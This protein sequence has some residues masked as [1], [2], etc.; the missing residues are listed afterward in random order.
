MPTT[1]DP[2]LYA[3]ALAEIRALRPR[4]DAEQQA[5]DDSE[6]TCCTGDR[7]GYQWHQRTRNLPACEQSSAANRAYINA[8]RAARRRKRVAA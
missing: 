7:S 8:F 2:E 3:Q 6:P 5:I 4:P 1:V